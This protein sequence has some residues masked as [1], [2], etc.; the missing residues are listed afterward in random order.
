MVTDPSKSSPMQTT[1]SR[2]TPAVMLLIGAALV[3]VIV[4]GLPFF[5]L[6]W[7][8]LTHAEAWA[9]VT[10]AWSVWLLARNRV[11]GWWVGMV[12]IVLYLVVFWRVRLFG[13][14]AIQSF[15]LLTSLYAIAVWQR[16]GS[17][18]EEKPVGR[19]TRQGL[20]LTIIGGVAAHAALW[21]TL[22][23]VEGALPFWD[24]LTTTLSFIGQIYLLLRLVENWF[25]WI[26][27]DLIYV[28]LYASRGLYFTSV[29]YAGFLVLA[30]FGLLNFRRLYT[31]RQRADE[32][33]S[34]F[35]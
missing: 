26:L 5:D 13:E 34:S 6:R 19:L 24:A 2:S 8:S 16:G 4:L 27:V 35:Q 15:Y 32:Y 31:E 14:V 1:R 23:S 3:S 28:P 29:L 9:V 21:Y 7:V 17:G 11:S 18:G 30:V 20:L 22:R 12:G 33:P 25:V 10:S